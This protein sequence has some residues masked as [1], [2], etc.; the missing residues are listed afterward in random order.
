MLPLQIMPHDEGREIPLQNLTWKIMVL[1]AIWRLSNETGEGGLPS[2]SIG[3]EY[4]DL[5]YSGQLGR[6][7]RKSREMASD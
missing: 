2:A 6:L 7:R 5:I 3:F 4:V 1:Y